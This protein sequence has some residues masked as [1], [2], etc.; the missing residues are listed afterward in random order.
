[1]NGERSNLACL[2]TPAGAAAIA[3]VR[4]LGPD[5][6]PFLSKHFS[7]PA[8][9]GHCVHG[10]LFDGQTVI[11][12]PVVVLGPDGSFVDICLHGGQWIVSQCLELASREGFKIVEHDDCLLDADSTI[13]REMLAAVPLARTEQAVRMLLAQPQQWAALKPDDIPRMLEDRSLWWMLH[14]PQIA[15]VGAANVGKSTLANCLFG[16]QKSITHDLPGTTRD[17]VGDWAN[18]DGLPVHLLDTPGQRPS[19]DPIEQTAIALSLRQIEQAH[20]TIVVL[21][22]TRPLEPEQSQI[23]NRYPRSL[24]VINKCDLPPAWDLRA[25]DAVHTVATAGQGVDELRRRIRAQFGCLDLNPDRPR[26]WTQ[27]Q[28]QALARVIGN[29]EALREIHS[30][31][32]PRNVV[33]GHE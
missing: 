32:Q 15:I 10:T 3:V 27:R 1:M 9:P 16:Q 28:R 30:E 2:L 20:L 29:P 21:D 17:W 22:V 5:V 14:P 18:I 23:R 7:R 8:M 25:F 4:L 24:L 33:V 12:D 31:N 26:W 19:T 6:P 13:E 11:D